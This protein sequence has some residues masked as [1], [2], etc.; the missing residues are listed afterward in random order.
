MRDAVPHK[1]LQVG[2]GGEHVL[3]THARARTRTTSVSRT[4]A[5]ARARARARTHA[6]TH[7]IADVHRVT[8]LGALGHLASLSLL[9][10]VGC[11]GGGCGCGCVGALSTEAPA[12]THGATIATRPHAVPAPAGVPLIRT[13][14]R[15]HSVQVSC[16]RCPRAATTRKR[17]T[18]YER[19]DN[20]SGGLKTVQ[21]AFSPA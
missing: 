18:T 12:C 19:V 8:V 14:M 1:V 4:H 11:V 16:S 15:F 9:F 21:Q 17:N 7:L 10:G 13:T 6:R 20:A 3:R 2:L 5:R